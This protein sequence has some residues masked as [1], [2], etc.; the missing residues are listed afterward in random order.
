MRRFMAFLLLVSMLIF[1][2]AQAENAYPVRQGHLNDLAGVLEDGAANDLAVL[3]QRLSEKTGGQIYVIT[4]H[5]L[6][7]KNIQEYADGLFA[8]WQLTE[9]DALLLMVIGEENFALELG[10]KAEKALPSETRTALLA[11][12]RADFLARNY[13]GAVGEFCLS[14]AKMTGKDISTAG[15]FGQA[16]VK[17][18]AWDTFLQDSGAFF[19]DMFASNSKDSAEAQQENAREET[20]SNWR[21]IIIWGLAIYFLFFRKNRRK[22]NFAHP[23]RR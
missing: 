21:T 6:G 8:D 17:K 15:L 20:R 5:F 10:A 4:R 22:Y 18:S 7:G 12:F 9:N 1:P 19:Q 3:S 23:P 11:Q 13:M 16:E 14:Y 2:V